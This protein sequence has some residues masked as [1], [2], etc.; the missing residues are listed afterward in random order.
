MRDG[1]TIAAQAR[2][3]ALEVRRSCLG[4]RIGRLNRLVARRFEH[5]LRP[6]GLSLAQVEVLGALVL[7]Q[8]PA[9]PADLVNLLAVER[10]TISRN[11]ALLEK[12]GYVTTTKTSPTGRSQRVTV[13]A[14]GQSVLAHAEQAWAEAQRV[15]A[16][17]LGAHALPTLDAWL[18][19]LASSDEEGYPSP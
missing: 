15:V 12:R 10:S 8:D 9:R 7:I 11:L 17:Q 2:R 3:M 19:K 1:E 6:L 4:V 18:E 16:D 14:E 13:T 5:A